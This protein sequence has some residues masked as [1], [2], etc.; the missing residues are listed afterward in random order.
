VPPRPRDLWRINFSRVQ[1]D[2]DRVDGKYRRIEG[3]R[4]HNWVWSPQGAINMHMPEHWGYLEFSD[5][6]LGDGRWSGDESGPAKELLRRIYVAQHEYQKRSGGFATSLREMALPN[7]THPSFTGPATVIGSAE[8]FEAVVP[9]RTSVGQMQH[10]HIRAD[11]K[12]W[13]ATADSK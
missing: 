12:L 5:Q 8:W 13:P 6:T 4:E 1:W 9:I 7:Y 11:S 2:T 10:W 3:R